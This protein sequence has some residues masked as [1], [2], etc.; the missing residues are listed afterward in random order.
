[1]TIKDRIDEQIVERAAWLD[2]PG[3]A[4]AAAR[5]VLHKM[6]SYDKTIALANEMEDWSGDAMMTRLGHM[7]ARDVEVTGFD[8]IPRHGGALMVCNHPTGIADGVVLYHLLREARPDLFFY[9]NS[10]I[11]KV[12]PQL[13]VMIAPVEWREDKR[14]HAKMRET[15]AYTRKAMNENRL[16][17]IFPSG[18]LA[19]RRGLR[20][21]ERPWMTSAAMIARKFDVPIIPVNIRARNSALFYLFDFIH[22]SLRDITLFHETLNKAEQPYRVTVGDPISPSALS[23]DA[24]ASIELLR[25]ATLSLGGRHA[26]EVSLVDMTRRPSWVSGSS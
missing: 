1:M 5:R 18:R 26:P 24:D 21:Y 25:K 4:V 20:L 12:V 7:L 13:E 9:A 6:L 3:P 22:P 19:K 16:G 10:D 2:Q 17:I 8:R 11:L 15:M 14:N 23:K